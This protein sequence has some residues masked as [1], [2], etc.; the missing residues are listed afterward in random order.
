M[1][2]G[3]RPPFRCEERTW[4]CHRYLGRRAAESDADYMLGGST[5]AAGLLRPQSSAAM[6]DGDTAH[7]SDS[8]HGSRA[9][10]APG[11]SEK[12]RSQMERKVV[13]P[14]EISGCE[15]MLEVGPLQES[16]LNPISCARWR[17]CK[18]PACSMVGCVTCWTYRRTS[19]L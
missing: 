19:A 15:D 13:H 16:P 18:H 8:P 1:S 3:S 2:Q 10:G 4:R 7:L 14:H 11:G 12:A 6:A 9:S 17:L 5:S